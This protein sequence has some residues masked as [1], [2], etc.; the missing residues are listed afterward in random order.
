MVTSTRDP[1]APAHL[2]REARAFWREIVGE[3]EL[4]R[5][6]RAVL[7][8]ALEAWDRMVAARRVLDENGVTYVDRFGA[9]RAR[10]EVAVERDAGLRLLRAMRELDLEG[11]PEADVRPPRRYGGR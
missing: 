8:V 7:Q 4:E 9:P 6:H 5:H 2:S 3:F 1:K 10:P 11:E